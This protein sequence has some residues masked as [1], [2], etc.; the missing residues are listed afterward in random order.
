M[1]QSASALQFAAPISASV[2]RHAVTP[3]AIAPAS[4]I[5]SAASLLLP[6]L[7][8][9]ERVDAHILRTA[10]E[11]SFLGSDADGRWDWKTAYEACEVAQI[12][13]LRKY[14]A[15]LSKRAN[16]PA[17][18]LAMIE[19]IST[20]LPTHTRR[21]QSSQALQ[22]FSTPVGLGMIA[23]LAAGI[24][25]HDVVLEPSA[26]TGLLAIH[27]ERMGAKLV[28]NEYAETRADL[29]ASLFPTA[30]VTRFDAA[31]LHDYLDAK[32]R[33]SVVLMNPPFSALA[34]V[35]GSV[36]DAAIRHIASALARL[37]EGGRLVVIT[38]VHCAPD[39]P[40]W[41]P[42]FVKLQ[43]RGRVVFSA[44]IDG[45]IYAKHGTTTPTRLT[46]IDRIPASHPDHFP[47]S[48]GMAPDT[49]TL[50]NWVIEHVPP[51][52]LVNNAISGETGLAAN[53]AVTLVAPLR[54]A[55]TIAPNHA[56]IAAKPVTQPIMP[57]E[58]IELVYETKDWAPEQ[59]AQLTDA[60]Y[61]P[62]ALQSLSIAGAVPHP[63][64][65]VQSA[66]MA[67]VAPPQPSYRPH[68]TQRILDEAML[69]DAQLESVIYA[70]E[71][72]AGFLSGAWAVDATYDK[73]DA[74]QQG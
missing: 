34:H 10:M 30:P 48:L 14:A 32:L 68:L 63:T 2:S 59:G 7:E 13:F 73:I 69:S 74:A 45:R 37:T 5:I 66:A 55:R 36:K 58:A 18:L 70:G 25:P 23:A 54:M 19:K 71:A 3:R 8:R 20:L 61:E 60:I 40:A 65:L 49:T 39:A 67:S 24:T 21:S 9:G 72:H 16:D 29:L 35:D 17:S 4:A 22:Q 43:E 33:P 1:P 57:V 27:A 64:A 41:T 46:V 42:A 38:G 50:L 52:A 6:H 53:A 51:R 62:Y 44:A 26:G 56:R 28:L 11:M 15:A 47:S 31:N 12:L